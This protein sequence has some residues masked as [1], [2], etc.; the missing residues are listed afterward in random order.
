LLPGR[1]GILFRSG[2]GRD[3]GCFGGLGSVV[4][5]SS[6]MVLQHLQR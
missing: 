6:L 4:E 5:R 1:W 3:W 2:S